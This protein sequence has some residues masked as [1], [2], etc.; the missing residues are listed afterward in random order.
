M[1][2]IHLLSFKI[3]ISK[4]LRN[5]MSHL[6]CLVW[7]CGLSAVSICTVSS[8]VALTFTSNSVCTN[9]SLEG[10]LYHEVIYQGVKQLFQVVRCCPGT[11]IRSTILT[12][13]PLLSLWHP[14]LCPCILSPLGLSFLCMGTMKMSHCQVQE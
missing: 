9:P 5:H 2:R 12:F 1:Y 3:R 14:F 13:H 6:T 8:Q 4:M 11:T 10:C 7:S